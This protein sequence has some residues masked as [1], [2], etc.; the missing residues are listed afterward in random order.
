MV[1]ILMFLSGD[2]VLSND[3]CAASVGRTLS[4]GHR[5]LRPEDVPTATILNGP[6][7]HKGT[8]D[9]Q[10]MLLREG[11]VL[12]AAVVRPQVLCHSVRRSE[13]PAWLHIQ[14]VLRAL[15]PDAG[16]FTH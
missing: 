15:A 16:L 5:L 6:P 1:Q 7:V 8:R 3:L 10:T 11:G 12:V 14:I 2:Q 13:K 9:G 4:I